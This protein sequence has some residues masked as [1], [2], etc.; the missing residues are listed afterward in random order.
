MQYLN[1]LFQTSPRVAGWSD[2]LPGRS[3]LGV[4][5]VHLKVREGTFE[6]NHL[7]SRDFVAIVDRLI[8]GGLRGPVRR[9]D[10]IGQLS[11]A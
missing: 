11:R 8:Q 5:L 9:H 4:P 7:L 10:A 3:L 2:Q 1:N 6:L